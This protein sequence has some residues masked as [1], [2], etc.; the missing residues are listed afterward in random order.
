MRGVFGDCDEIR[1][2]KDRDDSRD[3]EEFFSEG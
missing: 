3:G 2:V 1:A